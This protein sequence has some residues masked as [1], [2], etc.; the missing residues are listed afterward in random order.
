M[1]EVDGQNPIFRRAWLASNRWHL[2]LSQRRVFLPFL[3]PVFD[4]GPAIIDFYLFLISA[5]IPWSFGSL[6]C[7]S[8]QPKL[9]H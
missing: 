6:I 7:S 8:Y 9:K 5:L 1:Q 3:D 4:L 2:V